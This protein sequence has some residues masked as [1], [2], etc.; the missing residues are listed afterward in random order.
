MLNRKEFLTIIGVSLVLAFLINLLLDFNS[1]LVALLSVFVIIMI[2]VS[3]K[4]AASYFFELDTEIKLWKFK[5]WGYKPHQYLKR[6]FP[7]GVFFPIISKVIFF[8]LLNGFVWMASLVFEVKTKVYRSAKRHG[9]YSFSEISEDHLAYIAS[10][11]IF[12]NLLFAVIAYL[13]GFSDFAK[14][15]IWFVFFNMLPFSNLDGNKIF[16]G[17]KALWSFLATITLIALGFTFVV[18]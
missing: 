13:V 10:A 3:I 9:L 8:P 14:L 5:R 7:A 1:F 15:S 18:I 6:D 12:V 4:K 11:A 16:F 2:N 17:S